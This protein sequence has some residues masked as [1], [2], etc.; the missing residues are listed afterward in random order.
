MQA[1][2]ILAAFILLSVL[3]TH[4]QTKTYPQSESQSPS[5][6]AARRNDELRSA[7]DAT[8]E[9]LK[10]LKMADLPEG[11]QSLIETEWITGEADYG[12][13][14]YV[15]PRFTEATTVFE[16]LFDTDVPGVQ[17]YKRLL[18]MKAVSEAGTPILTRYFMIAYKDR[19]TS[20][21]K[22]LE[23]DN[24]AEDIDGN[25]AYFAQ[26]LHQTM[27]RSEQHNYLTYG[28]WLLLAG[29]TKEARE[30]LT[31]ALTASPAVDPTLGM[32]TV[33]LDKIQINALL[34]VIDRIT[35]P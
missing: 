11:R 19:R 29:R 26:T 20:K 18:D 16:T 1:R 5:Q 2:G 22:V 3:S 32:Q 33:E 8:D 23:T 17:G 24:K 7:R 6:D 13:N 27:L 25:I 9:F 14:F 15:R 21:W 10:A 35:A 30:A 4:A 31:T 28:H 12:E 34:A